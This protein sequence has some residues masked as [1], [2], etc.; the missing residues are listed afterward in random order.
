MRK[1]TPLRLLLLFLPLACTDGST[2]TTAEELGIGPSGGMLSISEGPLAGTVAE[3]PEGALARPQ[4]ISIAEARPIAHPGFVAIGPAIE[5][6]PGNLQLL[7]PL[8]L[9][10]PFDEN[11]RAGSPPVLLARGPSGVIELDT[12]AAASEPSATAAISEP[13]TAWV[14]E[15]LFGGVPTSE[16]LPLQ[17]GN[18][19]ELDNDLTVTAV[20]VT[21]EPNFPGETLVVLA[22]ERP[23]EDLAFYLELTNGGSGMR[24][25][26]TTTGGSGY[27]EVHA[28]VPFAP[29]AVTLGQPIEAAYTLKGFE[30]YGSTAQ[31]YTGTARLRITPEFRASTTT[32]LGTFDGLLVLRMRLQQVDSRGQSRTIDCALSLAR[33][34]G[35]VEV[36]MFGVASQLLAGS[37]GGQPI[38]P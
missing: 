20:E 28:A 37:V 7:Q 17:D 36:E 11:A 27:Q 31:N 24:G 5:L 10:L 21:D 30:P 16:L 33:G 26:R 18:R 35:P 12:T 6:R 23:R 19:W 15:R 22:F 14:G 25:V 38:A 32:P 29:P 13:V 34:V 3:F 8:L 2:G 4:R 9:T 1:R